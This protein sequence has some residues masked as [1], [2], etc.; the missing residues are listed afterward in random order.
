MSA[1]SK[2]QNPAAGRA[3]IGVLQVHQ[4]E[5]LNDDGYN[6]GPVPSQ[7]SPI[8]QAAWRLR[9]RFSL[10]HRIAETIAVLAGLGGRQ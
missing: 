8:A 4:A 9:C 3:A 5:Q 10:G 6:P 2:Q 7:L 1:P